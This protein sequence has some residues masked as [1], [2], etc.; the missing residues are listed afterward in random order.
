MSRSM[1]SRQGLRL[2]LALTTLVLLACISDEDKKGVAGSGTELGNVV[3]TLIAGDRVAA[4]GIPVTLYPLNGDTSNI[5][6]AKTDANGVFR[7]VAAPG[8]Y[9]LLSFDGQ[10]NGV[11]IDSIVAKADTKLDLARRVLLPLGGVSGY[12]QV[13]GSRGGQVEL[14]LLGSPFTHSTSPNAAFD[15]QGI[16]AGKYWLQFYYPGAASVEWPLL[17]ESGRE[18]VI[19]DTMRLSNNF[20]FGVSRSDTLVLKSSEIPYTVYDQIFA[21]GVDSVY[22][23]LNGV[24][25]SLSPE[26][27]M[28]PYL[29]IQRAMLNDTGSNLLELCILLADTAVKRQ[30]HVFVDDKKVTPWPYQAVRAVFLSMKPSPR[31][32]REYMDIGRFKILQHRTLSPDELAFWD[33][34]QPLLADSAIPAEIEIPIGYQGDMPVRV[35]CGV[36][37]NLNKQPSTASLPGD[38]VTFFL[39]PDTNYHGMSYRMRKDER[40]EDMAKLGW[41][42]KA[43]WPL[44]NQIPA[45]ERFFRLA[46]T[47]HPQGVSF[48]EVL[49]LGYSYNSEIDHC[50][51][52]ERE[53]WLDS[54]GAISE[55]I[56]VPPGFQSATL[57]LH[58][59]NVVEGI[60]GDTIPSQATHV[61][62][63]SSGQGLSGSGGQRRSFQLSTSEISELRNLLSAMPTPFPLDWEKQYLEK[64]LIGRYLDSTRFLF[65]DRRGTV[66]KLS[67]ESSRTL[68][69]PEDKRQLFLRLDAW[70]REKG[71]L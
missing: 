64:S 60:A 27:K 61:Y 42:A 33:R 55:N 43:Q 23:Q 8:S 34:S 1:N 70:L 51:S 3:G 46:P 35:Q 45:P 56:A 49:N 15:W 18:T 52:I 14:R 38:T 65:S 32:A 12:V 31:P 17:I 41:F 53:Y 5:I 11:S 58:F 25:Y 54:A 2:G 6:T 24:S 9:R 47:L 26:D 62:I 59:R 57:L 29:F 37:V 68:L 39:F 13:F 7:F 48:R 50:V 20:S 28:K 16:P 30:W 19:P 4:V 21:E 40:Y 22:W 66:I 67:T 10:G 69:P 44:A 71:Y 36:D 63:D